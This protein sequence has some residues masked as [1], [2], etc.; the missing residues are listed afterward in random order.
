MQKVLVNEKGKAWVSCEKCKNSAETDLNKIDGCKQIINHQCVR[1]GAVSEVFCEFRKSL[2]KD[3]SLNGTFSQQYPRK[4][5]AGK[6]EIK[7][8]SK[9]GVMLKTQGNYDFKPGDVL[10]L[11]FILDD[12][13]RS[14]I[15]ELIEV[16]WVNG[17]MLGGEYIQQDMWTKQQIGFYLMP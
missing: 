7:N 15:N 4:N 12:R 11:A 6:I 3:V 9:L 1:C 10:K 8:I 13:N 17:Q 14:K 16:K 5:Q 2:R